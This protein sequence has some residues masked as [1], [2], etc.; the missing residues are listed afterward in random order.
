ML[1]GTH[2]QRAGRINATP[3]TINPMPRYWTGTMVSPY[4][5]REATTTTMYVAAVIGNAVASGPRR[6]ISIQEPK[7]RPRQ[8]SAAQMRDDVTVA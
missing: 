8:A 1:L 6:R 4:S 2:D 7:V 3:T 5:I